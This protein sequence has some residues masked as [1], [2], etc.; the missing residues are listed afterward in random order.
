MKTLQ[1]KT[2]LV[3]IAVIMVIFTAGTVSADASSSDFSG[4][5][6]GIPKNPYQISTLEELNE[7]RNNLPACYILLND[8]DF[9]ETN[10]SW[11]PIGETESPFC[12]IFDGNNKTIQNSEIHQENGAQYAG[13]FAV[14]GNEASISNLILSN[15]Q[16]ENGRHSGSLVG[17]NEGTITNCHAVDVNVYSGNRLNSRFEIILG[18]SAGGLIG[19]NSGGTLINCS[20]S[21][22]ITGD[23]AGGLVGKNVKGNIRLSYAEA[24]VTGRSSAGGLTGRNYFGQ[25]KDCYSKGSVSGDTLAGGF[26]G[27]NHC[28]DIDYCYTSCSVEAKTETSGFVGVNQGKLNNCVSANE[29]VNN[30]P[31]LSK[32]YSPYPPYVRYIF[33]TG[34]PVGRIAC[35]SYYAG[36]DDYTAEISNCFSW[37]ETKSNRFRFNGINGKVTGTENIRNAFPNAVWDEWNT[38]VWKNGDDGFPELTWQT[39]A[40]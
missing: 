31:F 6:A 7:I 20:A 28:G 22:H 18:G 37:K 36:D 8:L 23:D 34:G 4:N 33:G 10:Q 30:R 38:D 27:G 29:Y 13:L 2:V 16:I 40:Q 11:K 32:E 17:Y 12:G 5:G 24:G 35:A 19:T 26:V 39:S 14:T 3:S 25:I 9:K 15:T 1:R 21:G